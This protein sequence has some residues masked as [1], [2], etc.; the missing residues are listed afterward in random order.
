MAEATELLTIEGHLR[1]EKGKN[2]CRKLRSAGE[3][4]PAN[5]L[6]LGDKS[7]L[8][9]ESKLLSKVW[10]SGG[11]F[12]LKYNEETKKAKIKEL[13]VSP[14]S[15]KLFMLTSNTCSQL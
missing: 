6:G 15:C 3:R 1:T 12:N 2:Y 11:V 5:L 9:L 8:E 4:I 14:V 13:Q 7:S 10:K